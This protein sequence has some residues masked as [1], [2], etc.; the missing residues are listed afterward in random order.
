MTQAL[1]QVKHFG[2]E[3]MVSKIALIGLAAALAFAPLPA[4]AVGRSR[5]RQR[6][7]DT[8]QGHGEVGH[9]QGSGAPQG[10]SE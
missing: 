6:G 1:C 10:H 5:C 4:P 8:Q 3:T 7:L 2:A 9:A